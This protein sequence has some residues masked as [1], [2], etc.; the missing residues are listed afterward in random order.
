MIIHVDDNDRPL[1]GHGRLHAHQLCCICS[2]LFS[3]YAIIIAS[4][5]HCHALVLTTQYLHG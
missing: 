2:L 3:N 5:E 4:L 1:S